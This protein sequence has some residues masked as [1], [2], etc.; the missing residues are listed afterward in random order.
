MKIRCHICA[1][2][3][4]NLVPDFSKLRR[5]TSDCR[6]WKAGGQLGRC[7]TCATV[8]S[9]V[10][11]KWRQECQEIYESYA[12]Y[13][14]S[15]GAEQR[16]FDASSGTSATR[17]DQLIRRVAEVSPIPVH[18]RLLDIGCGNGGFLRAF[19]RQHPDWRLSGSEY[20]EK[21][22]TE[23]ERIPG[24]EAF[25]SGEVKE[26]P[27]GFDIC[28]LIHVLEHI[29]APREFLAAVR[30]KL[31]PEG[32]LIIELPAFLDNPF[33]LL[34][35]DHATHFEPDSIRSLL[36]DGG[37]ESLHVTGHWIPKELSV[38]ARPAQSRAV[39]ESTPEETLGTAVHWLEAVRQ[40]ALELAQR[41][42]E[43]GLFGTSIAATWLGSELEGRIAFFVDEDPNRIGRT[44]LHLPIYGPHEVPAGR[45]VYVPLPPEMSASVALRLGSAAVRYHPV[46]SFL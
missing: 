22:R 33:E 34:I 19:N 9:A 43:F 37:F 39:R 12:I 32:L 13:H 26:L 14:Q 28:S 8:Q 45:D 44:H 1:E 3:S 20:D 5:V 6:P 30:G 25:Y 46:P 42:G 10:N 40:S 21:N 4:V 2:G 16:V 38:I 29:E 18:G 7:D 17:S 31:K 11:S 35:A 15:G 41:G 24:F 23:V 36:A 27:A